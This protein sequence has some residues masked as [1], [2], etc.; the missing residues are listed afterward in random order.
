MFYPD[1]YPSKDIQEE[2]FQKITREHIQEFFDKYLAQYFL[3]FD[4]NK[5]SKKLDCYH[6]EWRRTNFKCEELGD[7]V[8]Y[9]M[10]FN[11]INDC[12]I[13]SFERL[14]CTLFNIFDYHYVGV[15]E[16]I[17][18]YENLTKKWIKFLKEKFPEYT[19]LLEEYKSKVKNHI[20]NDNDNGKRIELAQDQNQE[21]LNKFENLF[22]D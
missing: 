1:L 9:F 19:H 4:K 3:T 15:K 12:P 18:D 11:I 10:G 13:L 16:I 6:I 7:N 8:V 17:I 14:G 2:M 20:E 5:F 22:S 21:D